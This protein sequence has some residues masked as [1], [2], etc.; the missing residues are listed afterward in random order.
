MNVLA[1]LQSRFHPALSALVADPAKVTEL[2]EMIRVA[3]DPKFGDYQANF[4]MP[5]GKQLGRPPRDIAAEVLA[6]AKLDD[7]CQPPELAGPGFINLRLLDKWLTE[8]LNRAVHDERMGIAP[9]T[10]PR[11]IV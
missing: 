5:L 3:Q 11:T 2:L 9:T 4:A 7:L 1:E 8:Q 6:Q 10:E